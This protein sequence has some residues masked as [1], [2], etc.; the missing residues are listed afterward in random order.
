MEKFSTL[1]TVDNLAIHF[2]LATYLVSIA[3]HFVLGNFPVA[4]VCLVLTLW[5]IHLTLSDSQKL[6]GTT[7][8]VIGVFTTLVF[9]F[10]TTATSWPLLVTT[11]LMLLLGCK[12]LSDNSRESWVSSLLLLPFIPMGIF[13]TNDPA[14]GNG[15]L[16]GFGWFWLT[17][18]WRLW[19]PSDNAQSS[20][21][22]GLQ[23]FVIMVPFIAALYF[24]M[25]RPQIQW[26]GEESQSST[27]MSSSLKP[28][29]VGK[30]TQ[31]HETAFTVQFSNIV[32]QPE[33]MYWRG[34]V[35]SDYQSGEWRLSKNKNLMDAQSIRSFEE[36][37]SY[38]I[39]FPQKKDRF[40]YVLENGIVPEALML[41]SGVAEIPSG[42]SKNAYLQYTGSYSSKFQIT[43]PPKEERLPIQNDNPRAT[44]FAMS[45]R[46]KTKNVKGFIDEVRREI[47][48]QD[49]TYTLEP[50]VLKE[51][52]IDDFLFS[53]KKGFCEH[54]AGTL[55]YLLR[56]AGYPARVVVGFQGAQTGAAPSKNMIVPYSAAHAWLEYW[57]ASKGSWMRLDPTS[58][59]APDR[60]SNLHWSQQDAY[61]SKGWWNQ[62][63][64]LTES[65]DSQWKLWVTNYDADQQKL[66]WRKLSDMS[67]TPILVV[68]L[69][70]LTV[71][72]IIK[73]KLYLVLSM[74]P[75]K[76]WQWLRFKLNLS[77][78]STLDKLDDYFGKELSFIEWKSQAEHALY[79]PQKRI[80]PQIL[81]WWKLFFIV[82][83]RS[84]KIFMKKLKNKLKRP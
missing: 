43:A 24:L 33:Q 35:L 18:L 81:N 45:L 12:H 73:E 8:S 72:G 56:Q 64:F 34:L 1:K 75:R 77:N 6:S 10:F 36:D 55:T 84:Y 80:K 62:L 67:A 29:D 82:E 44:A 48:S 32:M 63:M 78:A 42:Y 17:A 28:G 37:A 31:N 46:D 14:W 83:S 3:P 65:M 79:A 51:A 47:T 22:R 30:L 61:K 69:L 27:G 39:T 40:M 38:K 7:A 5:R 57:D 54:Y 2:V 21:G 26:N 71:F 49:F 13:L 76:H 16:F 4:M 15:Y 60:F 9:S 59:V 41:D 50:G 52:W 23:F 70:L 74:S 53:R 58:W 66:L 19:N 68:G 20:L 25:P 11:A